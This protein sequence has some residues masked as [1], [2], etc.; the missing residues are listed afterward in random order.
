MPTPF[1]LLSGFLLKGPRFLKES[2]LIDRDKSTAAITDLTVV[3]GGGENVSLSDYRGQVLLIVNTASKCGFTPQY[4]VLTA[5]HQDYAERGF[6]VLA[7][8]SNDFG[9]Q[10]PLSDKENAEF[11]DRKF[12]IPFPLFSKSHAH[13]KHISPLFHRL[14]VDSPK[15]ISGPI[16]W[17]FNKFLIDKQGRIRGR[18]GTRISPKD[19]SVVAAIEQLLDESEP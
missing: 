3:N 19:A 8:P 12:A 7:F 17:N 16:R 4:K 9:G 10:E 11:C 1:S 5:L 15:P 14:T 13:G 6:S 2:A 18:F